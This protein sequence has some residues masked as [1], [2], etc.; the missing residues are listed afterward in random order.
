MKIHPAL[1]LLAATIPLTAFALPHLLTPPERAEVPLTP[2]EAEL[3][4]A[5]AR[6]C[7]ALHRREAVP[8]SDA[9]LFL[10]EAERG[11][12]DAYLGLVLLWR[13]PYHRQTADLA[14]RQTRS[15]DAQTVFSSLELLRLWRD[16]RYPARAALYANDPRPLVRLALKAPKT[17]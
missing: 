9:R 7:A 5:R 1:V 17:D 15:T 16:P 8:A 12:S 10:T 4:R 13:T 2:V 11:V 3:R 6:V 14:A